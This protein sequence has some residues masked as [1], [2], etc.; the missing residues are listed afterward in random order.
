MPSFT[1]IALIVG[2]ATAFA[3]SILVTSL[4]AAG[5]RATLRLGGAAD[6]DDVRPPRRLRRQRRRRVGQRQR[7]HRAADAGRRRDLGERRAARRRRAGV[8]RH[9]GVRRRHGSAARDRDGRGIAPLPHR[10]RRRDLDEDVPEHRADGLLRLHVLLRPPPGARARRSGRRQ[11]PDPLD[12]RRWHGAGRCCRPTACRRRCPAS[13]RS[14]R[15]A[16]ASRRPAAATPGSRRAATPSHASSTPTT[17]GETLGGRGDAGRRA[18]RPPGSTRSH[19]RTRGSASRSAVTSPRRPMPR[20]ERRTR[21]T[22]EG[23]GRS[24]TAPASTA[25][26]SAWV[27]RLPKTAVAVGPTGS[28]VSRD[29]GR[30][31][32]RFAAG[33]LDA[34]DCARDGRR[35]GARARRTSPHPAR[36]G[37]ARRRGRA[38]RRALR[39]A[40]ETLADRRRIDSNRIH[41]PDDGGTRRMATRVGINGFGRIGRNFFRAQ[42]RSAR[43]S[44]SSRS[45]TSATRRRWR[46]S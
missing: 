29:G 46:T 5:P 16:R 40:S 31:W 38:G 36:G 44:R 30:S 43:T 41:P 18:G 14:P 35:A 11:V 7:R 6:R 1:R 39:R 10:R 22:A 45:T 28:D 12:R 21:P 25:P 33:S 8:P 27:P 4:S 24:R 2:L 9:R 42:Q 17:A 19:S 34:V 32:T 26:G 15:A 23:P 3:A 13:S 20:R 37:A